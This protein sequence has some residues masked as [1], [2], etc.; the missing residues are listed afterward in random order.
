MIPN[1]LL[2]RYIEFGG[3][4]GRKG[5]SQRWDSWAAFRLPRDIG[6]TREATMR[7]SRPDS[8]R[9]GVRVRQK[10]AQDKL[11]QYLYIYISVD[12]G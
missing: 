8:Q 4:G 2:G 7:Y 1:P 10:I 12:I 3:E 11:R 9:S 5:E 6:C